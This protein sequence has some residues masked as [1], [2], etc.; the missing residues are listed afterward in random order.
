MEAAATLAVGD[1]V[2]WRPSWGFAPE[3]PYPVEVVRIEVS[4][5]P[6]DRVAW[7]IVTGWDDDVVVDLANGKWAYGDQLSPDSKEGETNR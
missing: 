3:F 7:S 2:R 6:V 5:K 1:R 4:G